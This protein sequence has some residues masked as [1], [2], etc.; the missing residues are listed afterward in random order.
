MSVDSHVEA[1]S[2]KHHRI[3]ETID[4]E[5]QRPHPDEIRIMSLKREKLRLKEEIQRYKTCTPQASA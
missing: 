5:I 4:K 1:L 2:Q 3:E